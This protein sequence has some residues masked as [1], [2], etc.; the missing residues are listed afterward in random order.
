MSGDRSTLIR[1]EAGSERHVLLGAMDWKV[2]EFAL[3]VLIAFTYRLLTRAMQV[4]S[5]KYTVLYVV[6][7]Y[8]YVYVIAA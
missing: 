6:P 7:E 5:D 8:M 3:L 1:R 4:S 2:R